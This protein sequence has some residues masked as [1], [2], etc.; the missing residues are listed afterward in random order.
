MS[1]GVGL[2]D[3][4]LCS[5]SS[6]VISSAAA[7]S[8]QIDAHSLTET[9]VESVAMADAVAR[10]PELY[11]AID[12]AVGVSDS[13]ARSKEISTSIQDSVAITESF[14][15][16]SW[17]EFVAESGQYATIRY[18]FTLTGAAD[19]V[20]DV[21][22]PISSFQYRRRNDEPSYLSVVVPSMSFIADVM[23]RANG[24][25]RLELAYAKDGSEVLREIIMEVDYETLRWDEGSVSQSITIE[26]HRTE[27]WVGGQIF[28]P[29]GVSYRAYYSDE[30]HIRCRPDAY[31]R[32]GDVVDVGDG[33][34]C[35]ADMI[36]CSSD[37]SYQV[38]E[39]SGEA[40][41]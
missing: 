27:E 2:G 23:A 7:L 10:L 13:M 25:M 12:D 17:S 36:S 39:I 30:Y 41:T 19:G 5:S 16:L 33:A 20:A 31:V 32:P 9:I 1:D 18:Y 34:Y 15:V 14:E 6:E 37:A 28:T 11:R 35:T 24:D 3:E 22:I 26:G 8:D 21:V 38:M 40:F 4:I 29:T